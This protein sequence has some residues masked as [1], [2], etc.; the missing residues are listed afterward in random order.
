MVAS[1]SQSIVQRLLHKLA[2]IV[3]G[4][5]SIRPW[6]HQL[7][8]VKMGKRVWI[9]QYVYLD[10]LH[11]EAISIGDNTSLGLRTSVVTHFYWGPKR[12]SS[13]AQAVKIGANVFIGPHCVVLP[14][15][16]IGD[17]AVVQAGSV[18]TREVPPRAFWGPTPSGLLGQASVPLT[19]EYDYD[20]FLRG[21][22][23]PKSIRTT[24]GS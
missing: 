1:L 10:E 11:P 22:R 9:S 23:P 8:G 4:G 15:V 5:S 17:G 21:L 13:A 19:H 24:K 18:V 12:S 3:P 6:L 2:F 20:Q 16:T 7:R 14:G